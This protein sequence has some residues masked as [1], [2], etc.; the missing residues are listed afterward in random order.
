M[1]IPLSA[2]VRERECV[3]VSLS[4]SVCRSGCVCVFESLYVCVSVTLSGQYDATFYSHLL[5][6]EVSSAVK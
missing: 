5:G 3:L 6:A 2:C 4:T 1:L